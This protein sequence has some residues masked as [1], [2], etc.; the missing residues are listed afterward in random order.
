LLEVK[1]I[2]Y[3]MAVHTLQKLTVNPPAL[4]ARFQI[5][6]LL[7]RA[8]HSGLTGDIDQASDAFVAASRLAERA[9]DRRE[10]LMRE[11]LIGASSWLVGHGDHVRAAPVFAMLLP[12]VRETLERESP[13]FDNILQASASTL[14][15]VGDFATA[16]VQLEELVHLRKQRRY[17]MDPAYLSAL[18]NLATA[19][20]AI[21][22]RELAEPLIDEEVRTYKET[23]G[24]RTVDYAGALNLSASL[25]LERK[26]HEKAADLLGEAAEIYSAI[27]DQHRSRLIRH[28]LSEVLLKQDKRDEGLEQAKVVR[29]ARNATDR[30]TDLDVA[31]LNTLARL[32]VA[33]GEWREAFEAAKI[34]LDAA[35]AVWSDDHPKL[36]GLLQAY[37]VSALPESDTQRM[38][39]V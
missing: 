33:R 16:I 26:E 6:S 19:H 23:S 34:G 32:L 22:N 15:Q 35:A 5:R 4:A 37:W 17:A 7:Y 31:N 13:L 28:N 1:A 14:F 3:A 10:D 2:E 27:G 36:T 18:H 29:A 21:G 12:V 8:N 38:R 24:S 39:H 9:L 30:W 20:L 25:A 11:V